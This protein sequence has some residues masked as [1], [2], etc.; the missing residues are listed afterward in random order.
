VLYQG[1][2]KIPVVP[3]SR[4]TLFFSAH[5]IIFV[6]TIDRATLFSPGTRTA[7]QNGVCCHNNYWTRLP[8]F[9]RRNYAS[10]VNIDVGTPLKIAQQKNPNQN[11]EK[12]IQKNLIS[13]LPTLIFSRYE[14][15]PQV[16]LCPMRKTTLYIY[17]WGQTV[18]TLGKSTVNER[19]HS[20][21]NVDALKTVILC[22]TNTIIKDSLVQN[23]HTFFAFGP[24]NYT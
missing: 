14:P 2:K 9:V 13:D 21:H 5:P 22:C 18:S 12:N 15:E 1:L 6:N 24:V 11:H 17:S 10:L 20:S 19:W 7:C 3:V 16:F 4:S 8:K 23:C